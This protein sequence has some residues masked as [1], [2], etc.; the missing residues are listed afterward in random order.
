M[1]IPT[2]LEVGVPGPVLE[3]K[4]EVQRGILTSPSSY[5]G[6]VRDALGTWVSPPPISRLFPGVYEYVITS[7]G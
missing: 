4:D 1:D 2:T 6:R 3:L 5:S 7:D